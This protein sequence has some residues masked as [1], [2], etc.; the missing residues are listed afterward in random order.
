MQRQ[1]AKMGLWAEQGRS[2][3]FQAADALRRADAGRARGLRPAA[4]ADSAAEVPRL[5]RRPPGDRGRHGG[6]RRLRLHRGMARTPG[7]CATPIS[8]RSGRGRATWWH[9]TCCASDRREGSFDALRAHVA[10]LDIAARCLPEVAG[11][12]RP[13]GG[14]LGRA[15]GRAWRGRGGAAGGDGALQRDVCRCDGVG[16]ART[17]DDEARLEPGA[18]G[19]A[20]P[21]APRDPLDPTSTYQGMIAPS[22][23]MGRFA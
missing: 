14:S 23:G 15:A 11:L 4:R 17:L 5:P 16:G 21:G 7:C 19:A 13:C 18:D 2:M 10:G 6:A 8:A 1:L 20:A 9:W 3:M 22:A 12:A